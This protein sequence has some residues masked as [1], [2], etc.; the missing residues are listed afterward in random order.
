MTDPL[1]LHHFIS[2]LHLAH[3][4]ILKHDARPYNTIQ[5][6]DRSLTIN[7]SK[8]GYPNRTLW[9]LGDVSF[10]KEALEA[11]M[12]TI[13]PFWGQIN[14]I[15]GNHDDKVAWRRRDLFDE[16][17][18]SRYLQIDKETSVYMSHYAHR[19]WRN[20][21][22]GTYHLY[23]HSHG[24]LPGVGRSTDVGANCINYTPISLRDVVDK[25]KDKETTNHH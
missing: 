15:R 10:R 22:R 9:I 25:L 5:D 21:H 6:H 14:L 16:A 23:G 1:L 24:S 3:T 8:N 12:A 20:N 7:C 4:N 18:E 2:D 19:V 17:H 11:F 13:R